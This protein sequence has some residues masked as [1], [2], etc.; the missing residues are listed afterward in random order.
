MAGGF[1]QRG[2]PASSVKID[3]T[4]RQ[5]WGIYQ[6]HQPDWLCEANLLPPRLLHA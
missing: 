3:V 4:A 5:P 6:K 2:T 1:S